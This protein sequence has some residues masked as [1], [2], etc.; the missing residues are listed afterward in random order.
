MP[1]SHEKIVGKN[2]VTKEVVILDKEQG[3]FKRPSM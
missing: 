3:L 2:V 1:L